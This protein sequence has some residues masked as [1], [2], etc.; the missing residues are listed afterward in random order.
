ME[1][2]FYFLIRNPNIAKRYPYLTDGLKEWGQ[3]E[4]EWPEYDPHNQT[5]LN[6]S[7]S[8]EILH[9]FPEIL[10]PFKRSFYCH[11]H[12]TE[13]RFA[14]PFGRDAILERAP[15]EHA[16][17]SEQRHSAADST[18]RATTTDSRHS[19]RNWKIREHKRQ[20]ELRNSWYQVRKV[21]QE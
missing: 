15:A 3:Y 11:S 21:F 9:P 10:K 7:K 19:R 16:S 8:K 14:L 20:Q 6:L 2:I 18:E 1:C 5:Y 4:I 12:T 13:N 17:S